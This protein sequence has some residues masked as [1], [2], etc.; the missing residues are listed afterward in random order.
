M[1]VVTS[2]AEAAI[3]QASVVSIGNFDGLHLGHRRILETVVKRS[4][5]LGV[6]A[7][8]MTFSPHPIRFLAPD[9]APRMI[10]TLDQR[11]R[12]IE[13][14]GI[15]LLFIAKFDL[16]FSRL[17]PEEFVRQYLIDGFHARSVCVGGNFNFGYK[18]RGS[19]ETLRQFKPDFEIIE[20]PAVR[21]RGTIVSSSRIRELVG[22]GRVSK[23]CRL[24]GR[25]I[26]IE[27]KIVSGAGRGRTMKVP[28]LNLEPANE[29]IPAA[30]VYI[31]RI[32]LDNGRMLDAVTNIGTRPTFNETS[33]TV[34]TFVLNAPVPEDAVTAQLDFLHRLRD[35]RKF[36]SPEELRAQIAIDVRRAEKFFR[37]V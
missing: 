15:D 33:L 10:S 12:L 35:E 30:G 18:Q 36:D 3:S 13:S 34:E 9:R 27:G 31:T 22:A 21:V 24:L 1:K 19:I 17:L 11:V 23:A 32:A 20:V 2:L 28:T 5:E 37:R 14:T 8:A 29:L 7:A 26:G 16:P 6:Q 4:R 25:W